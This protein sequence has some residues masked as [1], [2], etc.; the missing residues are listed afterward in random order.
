LRTVSAEAFDGSSIETNWNQ[1]FPSFCPMVL[2]TERSDIPLTISSQLFVLDPSI[3]ALMKP[4]GD[5]NWSGERKAYQVAI[6]LA[7]VNSSKPEVE[8]R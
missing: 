6:R 4:L 5:M 3:V 7:Q 2:T 1:S 8:W